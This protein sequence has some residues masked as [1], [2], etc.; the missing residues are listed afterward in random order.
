MKRTSRDPSGL[1]TRMSKFAWVVLAIPTL[2][3][4]GVFQNCSK[5]EFETAFPSKASVPGEKESQFAELTAGDA[6]AFP[7]LKLVFVVDNSGTMQVNQISLASAFGKMFEGDNA[8][9]LAPFDSTAL[10]INTAQKSI[11]PTDGLFARL[12]DKGPQALSSLP[13]A[14]LRALRGGAVSDGKLAGDL[15]GYAAE[16][17]V[18]DSLKTLSYLPSPVLGIDGNSLQVGVRK[19]SGAS[20]SEFS[21]AFSDRIA[22]LD[23][24]RSAI[25]PA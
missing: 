9:N 25:D 11:A 4:V 7:P 23:P 17:V 19:L 10:I 3:L 22:V 21:K 2:A 18:V 20:V 8:T 1:P 5:V 6:K 16:S 15:A 13:L 24:A 12:P 14:D